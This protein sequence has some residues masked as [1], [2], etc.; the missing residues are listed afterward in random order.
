MKKRAMPQAAVY[1]LDQ[2]RRTTSSLGILHYSANLVRGI[3]ALPFPGFEVV[4]WVSG[5]NRAEMVPPALPAWMRVVCV[6]GG[7]GT[8]A[9]RLAADHVVAPWLGW[10]QRPDLIHFPKGFLPLWLPPGIRRLVTIHDTIIPYYRQ[11]YPGYFPRFKTAYFDALLRRSLRR[12]DHVITVSA[13]SAQCLDRLSPRCPPVTVIPSAGFNPRLAPPE[14][15]RHGI[16]VIGS[17]L[18]HKA[19]AETLR[20][21]DAYAL[22]KGFAEQ[23]TVTGVRRLEDIPGF[24]PPRQLR[25][26]VAGRLPFDELMERIAGSRAL[27]VLSEIEGFGLPLL[28]SYAVNTPVCF[29]NV[30]SMA[31]VL[32]GLPGGWDRASDASFGAALDACLQMPASQLAA[33][34]DVLGARYDWTRSVEETLAVYRGL[35]HGNAGGCP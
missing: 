27:V 28:E 14:R 1:L 32:E 21:L 5:A 26:D 33:I 12:A 22:A 8:G 4:L 9:R 2:D 25:L 34:R 24:Q 20:R 17:P 23:V 7:F 6:D 19:T 11:H 30:A 16:M 29:R 10:R 35:L 3:A 31:E 18:P 13:F 15:P